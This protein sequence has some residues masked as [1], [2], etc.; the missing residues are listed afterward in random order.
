M[1]WRRKQKKKCIYSFQPGHLKAEQNNRKVKRS[2][3]KQ[4]WV[5]KR[6]NSKYKRLLSVKTITG[7]WQNG[8][9]YKNGKVII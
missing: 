4:K 3:I 1:F 5:N 8:P 7:P 2:K 6:E 9:C